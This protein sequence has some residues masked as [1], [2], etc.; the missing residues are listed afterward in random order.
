MLW[1]LFGVFCLFFGFFKDKCI[2]RALSKQ[3]NS[4]FKEYKCIPCSRE[5]NFID[6]ISRKLSI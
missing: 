3:F 6:Q 2:A 5:L 1:V 4:Y